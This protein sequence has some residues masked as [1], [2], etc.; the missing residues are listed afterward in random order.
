VKN[1]C[2]NNL[3]YSPLSDCYGRLGYRTLSLPYPGYRT[4]RYLNRSY[5]NSYKLDIN[6]IYIN[7]I[8]PNERIKITKEDLEC[9]EN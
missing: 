4:I 3:P 9:L 2:I 1:N 8:M 6:A 7:L 5:P